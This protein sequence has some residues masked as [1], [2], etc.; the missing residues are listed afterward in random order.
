MRKCNPAD[1][2]FSSSYK[3]LFN[4]TLKQEEIIVIYPHAS[5]N[6]FNFPKET[7]NSLFLSSVPQFYAHIQEKSIVLTVDKGDK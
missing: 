6:Q 4:F 3:C 7:R 1:G 2:F 5:H